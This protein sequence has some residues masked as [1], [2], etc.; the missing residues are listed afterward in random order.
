MPRVQ[1][2]HAFPLSFIKIH[3]KL[4]VVIQLDEQQPVCAYNPK[5]MECRFKGF[6][7][8]G[9]I[10]SVMGSITGWRGTPSHPFSPTGFLI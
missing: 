4:N 3:V 5:Q 7:I 6:G 8:T 10:N 1:Q 2:W 9:Y